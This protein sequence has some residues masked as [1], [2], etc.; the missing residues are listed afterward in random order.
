VRLEARVHPGA[1]R[2]TIV[3]FDG[4]ILRVDIG[5]PA[6]H[7]RANEALV[8]LLATALHCAKGK[9]AIR[10]GQ[11]GRVKLLE[12]DLPEP[13]LTAWLADLTAR[14]PNRPPSE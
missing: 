11:L 6:A 3:G 4:G 12:I 9:I 8:E 1:R 14:S 5:A 10:R 13:L 2:T 7:N